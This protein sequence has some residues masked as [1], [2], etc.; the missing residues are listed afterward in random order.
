MTQMIDVT[1]LSPEAVQ[2]VETLVSLLRARRFES[3]GATTSIFDLF[4]MAEVVRSGEDIEA[5]VREERDAWGA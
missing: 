2:T 3:T 1:G 5:R 4:G